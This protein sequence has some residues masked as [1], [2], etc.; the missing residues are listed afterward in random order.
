MIP[1]IVMVVSSRLQY[2]TEYQTNVVTRWDTMYGMKLSSLQ[3]Y[4][5]LV[6]ERSSRSLVLFMTPPLASFVTSI[7]K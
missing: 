1:R 5:Q 2:A 6:Y 3:N 7:S 4:I